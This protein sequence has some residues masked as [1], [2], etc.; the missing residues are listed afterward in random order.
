[1]GTSVDMAGK[2]HGHAR[3]LQAHSKLTA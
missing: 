3:P 1:M 2:H